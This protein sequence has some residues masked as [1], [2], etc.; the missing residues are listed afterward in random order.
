VKESPVEARAARRGKHRSATRLAL[1]AAFTAIV[2]VPATAVTAYAGE[3][4][5]S[6]QESQQASH[7]RYIHTMADGGC[8][9][10]GSDWKRRGWVRGYECRWHPPLQFGVSELWVLTNN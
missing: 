5:A 7:W 4:S 1:A 8:H 2:L 3:T 6:D 9:R 10:D